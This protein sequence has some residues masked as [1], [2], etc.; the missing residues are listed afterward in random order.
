MA[1][2][3]GTFDELLEITAEEM[4][5]VATALRDMVL[6]VHED[7][8][9][10]VRLGDRAATYGV[11]PKKMSEGHTY[12]LPYDNWVNLGF[13]HGIELSDPDGLLDG[14]GARMRHVK[15]HSVE[16]AR[17]PALRDLVSEALAER[18]RALGA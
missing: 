9:E 2:R 17:S 4:R 5:P 13:Y 3:F 15:V 6:S 12:V 7:A 14:T 11:G 16:D 18:R 1:T 8:V 10:V